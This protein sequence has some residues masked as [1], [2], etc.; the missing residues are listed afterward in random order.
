MGSPYI[1]LGLLVVGFC[2]GFYAM[3]KDG[4]PPPPNVRALRRIYWIPMFIVLLLCALTQVNNV[5]AAVGIV[6]GGLLCW[7][8]MAI[9][10]TNFLVIPFTG[11]K[12][13]GPEG[14]RTYMNRRS[15]EQMLAQGRQA[16]DGDG[17]TVRRAERG[18][19]RRWRF[20]DRKS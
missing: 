3:E 9:R 5:G 8:I 16:A 20:R 4:S 14:K 17:S 2:C 18:R 19:H 7:S 6:I 12:T 1:V 11:G 15:V 13:L 10:W